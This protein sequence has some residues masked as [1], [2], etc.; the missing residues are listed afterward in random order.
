MMMMQ[1][2][3]V[4]VMASAEKVAFRSLARFEREHIQEFESAT[5]SELIE[6]RNKLLRRAF[7][8]KAVVKM[9]RRLSA[10]GIEVIPGKGPDRDTTKRLRDQFLT[11]LATSVER[12]SARMEAAGWQ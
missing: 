6:I 11:R 3:E 8:P 10:R 12:A 1:F 7:M 9:V 2:Y 5:F 4:D